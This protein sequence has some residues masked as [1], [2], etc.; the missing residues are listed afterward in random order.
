MVADHAAKTLPMLSDTMLTQSV[1]TVDML[2]A[3]LTTIAD[4][5]SVHVDAIENDVI[6]YKAFKYTF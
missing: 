4:G 2:I 1:A 3:N 6:V 5:P